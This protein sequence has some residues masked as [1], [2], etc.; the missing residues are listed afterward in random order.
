[1]IQKKTGAEFDNIQTFEAPR[2]IQKCPSRL[3]IIQWEFKT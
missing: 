1:M 2:N 3:S